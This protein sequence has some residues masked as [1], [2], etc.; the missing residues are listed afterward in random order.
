MYRFLNTA[1]RGLALA[2]FA[3][4]SL[5]ASAHAEGTVKIGLL[6][7]F[8][9][10]FADFGEQMGNGVALYLSQHGDV[11]AGKKIVILRRD[12]TGANPAVAKRLAQDL[13][14][15]DHVAFLAGF[16]LTPNALAVAPI[17]TEAKVPMVIMNA[18]TS[19]ITKKSPYFVRFS[20]TMP[21]LETPLG[22]WAAKQGIKNVYVAVS[23]YA[24]GYEAEAAF[25]KAFTAAG[26]KVVGTVRIPL[27]HPEM[28][29]YVQRIKDANPQGVFLFLPSGEEPPAFIRLFVDAGLRKEG[30]ALLGGT[31]IV[32]DSVI[33]SLGDKTLGVIS[34]QDYSYAHPSTENR[35]YVKAYEAAFGRRERPNF[36]S[37]AAY[38]G[39]AAMWKVID[40]LHGAV[41]GD[42]A[43]AAFKGMKLDS[44]RGPIEVDPARRELIESVYIRR[45]ARVHGEIVNREIKT[46]P[47][48]DALG[49]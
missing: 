34:V 20:F 1:G 16:G 37:V 14:I 46:F 10:P 13:V 18:A 49:K 44:P 6:A 3:L 27:K 28:A 38:D 42:K 25:T 21:Q 45:V 32:D 31:A 17:G 19:V 2:L 29:P 43:M 47:R 26:G 24:P 5:A 7:P 11:V 39:M 30:I 33:N 8:S 36:M 22:Q 9:G 41:T 12:T 40:K 48:V 15:R 23:D 4:V 35:A